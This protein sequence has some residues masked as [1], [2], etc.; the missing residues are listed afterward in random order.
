MAS[1]PLTG[2]AMLG[3]G[4]MPTDL[5]LYYHYYERDMRRE[6]GVVVVLLL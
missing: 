3:M 1:S 2:W 4:N 6:I 5:D